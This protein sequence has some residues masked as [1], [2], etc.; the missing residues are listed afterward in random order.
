LL[1]IKVFFCKYLR[2]PVDI[3]GY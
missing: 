2:V 3:R 1:N